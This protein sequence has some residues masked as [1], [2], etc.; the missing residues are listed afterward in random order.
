[1]N[2]FEKEYN[3]IWDHCDYDL[4]PEL[5][6][7]RGHLV[8][9]QYIERFIR[10]FLLKANSILEKGRLSYSQKL[11]LLDSF[12]ILD[13]DLIACHRQLNKL[14]NKMAHE[15]EYTVTIED[16]D[17]IGN[18][19]GKIYLDEK[20]NRGDDLKNLLC[21]VIGYI[22][23]GLAHYVVEYEAISKKKKDTLNKG[24]TKECKSTP[25][26]RRD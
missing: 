24:R 11:S 10:L 19:M 17:S 18:Q 13:E 8:S 20:A 6:V 16:I 12:G 15:L 1:M 2:S 21:T 14:R 9:E 26:A 22:C 23:G 7:L 4:E 25:L 5:I 3:S